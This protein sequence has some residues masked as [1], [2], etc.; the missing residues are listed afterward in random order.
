MTEHINGF[1]AAVAAVLAALTALWGWFGWFILAWAGLMVLDYITGSAAACKVGEWSSK[2]ARD[3]LWHKFGAIVAVLVTGVL[4]YVIGLMLS[5]IPSVTLPFTYSV[6]I[7]PLVV[8]WYILTEI[9]SI[10]ENA[11]K[12]GAP[13]PGWLRRAVSALKAGVD[14]AGDKLG[15]HQSPEALVGEEGQGSEASP[16]PP[17]GGESGT[18][19]AP[20]TGEDAE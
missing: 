14:K 11:G 8:A 17:R 3:G 20:T 9:G 2:A 1:K 5:N 16:V 18:D 10:I 6:L 15:T 12:L 19:F 4:D 7:C 13:M